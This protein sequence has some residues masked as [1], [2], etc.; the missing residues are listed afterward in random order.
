[1]QLVN[2]PFR[3]L[4]CLGFYLCEFFEDGMENSFKTHLNSLLTHA[5][6]HTNQDLFHQ[7]KN[8]GHTSKVDYRCK[9]HK[10]CELF[11][12]AV[13]YLSLFKESWEWY[14][15]KLE[16]VLNFLILSLSPTAF[17]KKRDFFTP[18]CFISLSQPCNLLP[19]SDKFWLAVGNTVLIS[20]NF[21]S[22]RGKADKLM[23]LCF[24]LSFS[25]A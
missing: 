22:F 15:E 10:N 11:S 14:K 20:L 8:M 17:W 23:Q 21:P 5:L 1:M 6:G 16:I 13:T 7:I 4:C 24:V 25:A 3:R 9:F 19:A 2:C 12:K 18:V